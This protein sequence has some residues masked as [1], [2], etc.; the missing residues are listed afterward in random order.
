M[1]EKVKLKIDKKFDLR[2]GDFSFVVKEDNM[3]LMY[4]ADGSNKHAFKKTFT[5]IRMSFNS[6]VL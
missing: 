3:W 5:L 6:R 4:F 2:I 1:N